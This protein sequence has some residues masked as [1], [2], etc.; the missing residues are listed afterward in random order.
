MKISVADKRYASTAVCTNIVDLVSVKDLQ[1]VSTAQLIIQ[2]SKKEGK[3]Q[4]SIQ[5]STTPDQEYH[6]KLATSQIHITNE[7]QEVSPF[8]A[9]DPKASTNKRAWKYIKTKQKYHKRSTKGAPP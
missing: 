7:S 6:G 9:G 1:S 3:D 4:E 5:S 8:P 2:L